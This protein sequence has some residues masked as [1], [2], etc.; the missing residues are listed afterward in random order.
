MSRRGQ[1]CIVHISSVGGLRVHQPGVPYDVTKA[2][3]DGLTR[4][5]GVE[6][7][8]SG[9]RVNA[10]APGAIHTERRP[11]LDDPAMQAIADRIPLRR[12]GHPLEIGAVV[13]FLASPDASYITGQVIYVDGGITTQLSPRG[14]P[15]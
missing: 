4:A 8:D 3:L 10:I 5:M 14:Q 2:A 6:L 13:A 1:G 9:I 7:A 11:P 15:I 12:F